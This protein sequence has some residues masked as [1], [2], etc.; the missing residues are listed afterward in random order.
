[1]FEKKINFCPK[2]EIVEIK[3]TKFF[4]NLKNRDICKNIQN[5]EKK[6]FFIKNINI[7]EKIII[8]FFFKTIIKRNYKIFLKTCF[9]LFRLFTYNLQFLKLLRNEKIIIMIIKFKTNI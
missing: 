8:I 3:N 1:M 6:N 5:F 7:R 2:L 9:F 4:G